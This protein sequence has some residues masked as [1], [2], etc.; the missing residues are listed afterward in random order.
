M[1]RSVKDKIISARRPFL[2]KPWNDPAMEFKYGL[3]TGLSALLT[4]S[5]RQLGEEN[6]RPRPFNLHV[7]A[8]THTCKYDGSRNG[9][10][11]NMSALQI[12]MKNFSAAVNLTDAIRTFQLDQSDINA[13]DLP[14][15]W[16]L[17]LISRASLALIAYP[18]RSQ[19]S[20]SQTTVSDTLASQYQFISGVFMICRHMIE[21]GHPIINDN[22]PVTPT[23]LYEYADLH[24]IFESPNGMVCAGS[25][26]K[27]HEFLDV[28]T[29]GKSAKQ[30]PSIQN[31]TI[32]DQYS[33]LQKYVE[34][35][36]GWYQYAL[37]CTEF[38]FFIEKEAMLRKSKVY[39]Q[40]RKLYSKA[41]NTYENMRE[42]SISLMSGAPPS[43]ES[44]FNLSAL[45]RQNNLLTL[46]NQSHLKSFSNK[47]I[48]KRL[49]V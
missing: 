8:R 38:D 17:Y 12:A 2:I 14:G 11:I 19:T 31:H 29:C 16:D 26:L 15:I 44:N 28:V 30:E 43:I 21:S 33:E 41:A 4:E 27:I 39:P 42:Y 18:L 24:G 13:T 1:L 10:P 32:N 48:S 34:H 45:K 22:T 35:L 37:L 6:T 47:D 49:N 23:E 5:G 9:K 3:W 46:L 7:P 25:K 20:P 40:D 36:D